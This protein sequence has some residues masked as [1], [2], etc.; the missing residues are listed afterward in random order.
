MAFPFRRL[1]NELRTLEMSLKSVD[2]G[3]NRMVFFGS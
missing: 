1:P 3:Q 2:E